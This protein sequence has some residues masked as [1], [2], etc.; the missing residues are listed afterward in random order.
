[1]FYHASWK[2]RFSLVFEILAQKLG[3]C[4]FSLIHDFHG[5]TKASLVL[6]TISKS[7]SIYL[8]RNY[9]H[10]MPEILLCHANHACHSFI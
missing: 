6:Y 10:C 1:M 9:V 8:L 4:K 7:L 5:Y 3:R 2:N